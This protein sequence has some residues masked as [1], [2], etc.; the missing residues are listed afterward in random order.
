M[1][2]ETPVPTEA[3]KT[4]VVFIG[5]AGAGK[6]T[7]LTQIGGNF[8]SGAKFRNGFT[9]DVTVTQVTLDEEEVVLIDVPG[10]SDPNPRNN[11]SNAEKLTEALTRNYNYKLFFVLKANNSGLEDADIQMMAT[12]NACVRDVDDSKVTFGVFINQI[13][14]RRVYDM[15]EKLA[16]Q[17]NLQEFLSSLRVNRSA[18]N[19]KI[20]K[21]TLLWFTEH[22][23]KDNV[24]KEEI[25]KQV[26]SREASSSAYTHTHPTIFNMTV[27]VMFIGSSGAG[28]ST[29]LTYITGDIVSGAAKF[30]RGLA[31]NVYEAR[32]EIKGK[33]TVLMD[34]PNFFTHDSKEVK[35]NTGKLT[36][37]LKREYNYMVY[38]VWKACNRGP[39]DNELLMMSKVNDCFRQA[40][41]KVT[42]RVIV[43]Q[44][45]DQDLYNIY[46]EYLARDKCK[47]CFEEMGREYSLDFTISGV[48]LL[49]YTT[50]VT[51][52][53]S[54][55][56][57]IR[58]EI[59]S[60]VQG[61]VNTSSRIDYIMGLF[62]P[63]M[64]NNTISTP[65]INAHEYMVTS[66][67]RRTSFGSP[68]NKPRNPQAQNFISQVADQE[69]SEEIFG[70]EI[71]YLSFYGFDDVLS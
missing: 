13:L 17:G 8:E 59:V 64:P 29:L 48:H 25:T 60:T 12:V 31:K 50:D 51:R 5:N 65:S 19:I 1:H 16:V 56:D 27:A 6:S 18:I 10:L 37:L 52:I 26:K 38:F 69:P 46:D 3:R 45:K 43:N 58:R 11:Q 20:D 22:G 33:E 68:I 34:V 21:V 42:L 41:C 44:I 54:A 39:N 70:H 35:R 14:E 67:V 40:G 53:K 15:Y 2:I 71:T 61:Y 7:L 4:A 9:K 30:R 49:R 66:H 28:K 57:P 62:Y 36:S 32:V 47:S 24:L 63:T 23:I 55:L